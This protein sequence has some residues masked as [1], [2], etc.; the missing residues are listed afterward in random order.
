MI[1]RCFIRF[2]SLSILAVLILNILP[3]NGAVEWLHT[4]LSVA[5]A[6]HVPEAFSLSESPLGESLVSGL[7][8]YAL[9]EVDGYAVITGYDGTESSVTIPALLDAHDVVGIAKNALE[10]RDKVVLHGNILYLAENAFGTSS[11]E[12]VSLNG[13]YGFYWASVHGFAHSTGKDYELV[14]GV[15]DYTDAPKGRI[16]KRSEEYVAFNRLE[17]LRLN[18]GSIIWIK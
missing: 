5:E 1:R 8:H 7:W 10:D 2:F 4:S 12:I 16:Q 14:P 17:G 11:P 13:T 15:I 3:L 6:E 18:E 9:R